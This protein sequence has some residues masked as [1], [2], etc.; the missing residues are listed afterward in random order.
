MF[1]AKS[2]YKIQKIKFFNFIHTTIEQ[3][4]TMI[5]REPLKVEI[6][7]PRYRPTLIHDYTGGSAL[8]GALCEAMIGD[9]RRLV[10]RNANN[11]E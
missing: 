5:A 11:V 10:T 3:I 7:P 2:F 6:C 8:C 9:I 1:L 4:L